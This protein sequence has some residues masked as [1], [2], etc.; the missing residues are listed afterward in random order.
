[1]EDGGWKLEDRGLGRFLFS[2]FYFLFS[3][4]YFL[5]S[6]FYLLSSILYSRFLI[7]PRVRV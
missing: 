1:M 2:I 3:I 5:S 7:V 4:F 6:I